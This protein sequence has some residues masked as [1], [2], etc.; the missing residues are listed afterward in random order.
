LVVN[1]KI[2]LAKLL[3]AE[4]AAFDSYAD[5]LD[6]RCHPET[7]VKLRE[8]I[9]QWADDPQGKCI[10]WLCGIAGT[11]KSTISRTVAQSFADEGL[12]AASFFFK[13]G[14]G[15]RGNASRFF[16]TIASQMVVKMPILSSFVSAAIDA[17]PSLTGKSV[18]EQFE[19]LIL[20]PLSKASIPQ[21]MSRLVMVI[22]ALDECEREGDIKTILHLLTHVQHIASVSV[23]VFITSRPELPVRLGFKEVSG[24]AYQNL[25]LHE[26]PR[27]TIEHDITAVLK[28]E[29]KKTQENHDSRNPGSPLPSGWPGEKAI[30]ILVEMAI[31]LFIF[32]AT[33]SRFVGDVRWDPQKRLQTVLT[34]QTASQASKLDRTY[35][36]IL[37]GLLN[38]L[39][40]LEKETLI[41]EFQI[42]VGSIILFANPL[43]TVSLASLLGIPE[44]TVNCRLDSLHSVLSVPTDRSVPVRLLHLSFREFLTDPEKRGKYPF[45]VDP[46]VAHEMIATKCV[47]LMS[48]SLEEDVCKLECPGTIRTEIDNQIIDARLPAHVQY[49][50]CYWVHHLEQ[51]GVRIHDGCPVH[52]MLSEHFLHWLE[53]LALIGRLAESIEMIS[54]LKTLLDVS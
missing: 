25:I 37:D 15:D 17:D 36:P 52:L 39:S 34:Y 1:Q 10:F 9:Q 53:A 21:R 31:P 33:V 4:G 5:E 54:I 11:G 40:N 26:I 12:L 24:T 45:W 49:A 28:H 30:H 8:Q 13:R 7:R 47:E 27:S 32:A 43:S 38:G 35:F 48:H 14:E 22:D 44:S 51:S 6:A 23:R 29:L 42:V 18:K 46:R 2:D 20:Q 50:C 41:R 16:S 3:S 19:K